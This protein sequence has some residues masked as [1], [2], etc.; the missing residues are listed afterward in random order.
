ME[1][2]FRLLMFSVTTGW[3]LAFAI[4]ILYLFI[5]TAVW[6]QFPP[7]NTF[8]RILANYGLIS[9]SIGGFSIALGLRSL[10]RVTPL[11]MVGLTLAWAV[12]LAIAL[13]AGWL[14]VGQNPNLLLL[15]TLIGMTIGG[16]VGGF[17][18]ASA[19]RQVV[20]TARRPAWRIAFGWSLGLLIANGLIYALVEA[21]NR[22]GILGGL[23]WIWIGA[24]LAGAIA[25]VIGSRMMIQ[26]CS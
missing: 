19:M 8:F 18:T 23:G 26:Q 12:S 3:T 24:W 22:F 11:T 13:M 10:G 14:L 1:Q 20:S 21:T 5:Q 17:F 25:G 9:G 16:N 2:R 15:A 7:A 6:Y 4:G